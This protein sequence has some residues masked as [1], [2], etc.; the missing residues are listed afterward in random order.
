MYGF[1]E[2]AIILPPGHSLIRV[3]VR[4]MGIEFHATNRFIAVEVDS[5]A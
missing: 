2:T 1:S 5:A 4:R 3:G